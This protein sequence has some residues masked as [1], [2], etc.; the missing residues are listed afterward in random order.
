MVF[1]Q[2]SPRESTL[3][4]ESSSDLDFGELAPTPSELSVSWLPVLLYEFS[5][6]NVGEKL[7]E[8]IASLGNW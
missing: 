4:L 6:H 8:V 1:E 5:S 7:E 3:G 2:S